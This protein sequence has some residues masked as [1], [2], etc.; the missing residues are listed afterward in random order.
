VA[1]RVADSRQIG[2]DG[3]EFRETGKALNR[4]PAEPIVQ[5][6]EERHSG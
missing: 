5:D 3:G 2:G 4:R 1:G 6:K